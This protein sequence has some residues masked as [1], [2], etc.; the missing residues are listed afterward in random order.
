MEMPMKYS[1]NSRS[2][3][4]SVSHNFFCR[5]RLIKPG[6]VLTLHAVLLDDHS[7]SK[8]LWI[9]PTVNEVVHP[10]SR[11]ASCSSNHS[12]YVQCVS[13]ERGGIFAMGRCVALQNINNLISVVAK[14]G[15]GREA[16]VHRVVENV[17]HVVKHRLALNQETVPL[18]VQVLSEANRM[19]C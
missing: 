9:D 15:E 17:D 8:R 12:W 4:S 19:A 7:Y 5:L 11:I 14:R 3:P 6:D 2:I 10:I 13:R 18:D 1:T 16:D